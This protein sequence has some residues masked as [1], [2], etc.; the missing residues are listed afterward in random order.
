M[1]VQTN[2]Q[3]F[4]VKRAQFHPEATRLQKMTL[5]VGTILGIDIDDH[6]THPPN[7]ALTLTQPWTGSVS[8]SAVMVKGKGQNGWTYWTVDEP[9]TPFHGQLIDEVRNQ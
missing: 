9:G 5:P 3:T 4:P 2:P 7:G 8:A 6:H 1:Q